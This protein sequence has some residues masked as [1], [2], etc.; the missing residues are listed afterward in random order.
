MTKTFIIAEIGI[1]HNGDIEIA[2][3]LISMA[4]NSGCDAV[5]FQKRDINTVYSLE[6]LDKPRQSPWGITQREQKQG[7]EFGKKEYDEINNYCNSNNIEWFASAWDIKS[8]QFLDS[9]EFKYQK[10]ASALITHSAFLEEL[11]KRKKHTFIS[12][13]MSDYLTIDKAVDIFKKNNCSFELMHTVSAYPCPEDKLNLHLIQKLKEKYKCNVGY[14]GHEPSVSPSIIAVALGAS[15]LE[16]HIT[17]DR[18]MYGSDQ[19]AS[20]EYSGLREL[21]S[22]VRKIPTAIGN[23]EKKLFD[24]EKDVAKKLRYWEI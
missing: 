1:N 22:V 12:T 19:S 3:K 24:C 10:V 2:K 16:R 9:Y 15:S 20:L 17:L 14:S 11:S 21:V 7:L 8:L 23:E 18:S 4:K 5:K 13:G 6:E